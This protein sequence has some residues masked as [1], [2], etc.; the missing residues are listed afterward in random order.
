[1]SCIEV[2]WKP[3][4]YVPSRTCARQAAF[5]LFPSREL[6]LAQYNKPSSAIY[7]SL[8]IAPRSFTNAF[9]VMFVPISLDEFLP[10]LI[11]FYL[12]LV[13]SYLYQQLLE[14]SCAL[15]HLIWE[16]YLL[17]C[18]WHVNYIL[19]NS[20]CSS[21]RILQGYQLVHTIVLF[22][23][24]PPSRVPLVVACHFRIFNQLWALIPKLLLDGY[25]RNYGPLM[26]NQKQ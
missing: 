17:L 26:E 20:H 5:Q 3:L 7:C 6:R 19:Y 4:S 1:M 9:V 8:Y 16:C 15:I 21:S 24:V 11:Y 22:C 25:Y 10:E 18:G 23:F 13:R 14:T 2:C 12:P